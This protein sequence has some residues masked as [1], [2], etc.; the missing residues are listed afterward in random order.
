MNASVQIYQIA[1]K[2]S[3]LQQV[4]LLH[5]AVFLQ[6]R[7]TLP[8]QLADNSLAEAF[9]WFTQLPVDGFEAPRR[10]GFPEER[11]PL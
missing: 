8:A 5:F 4:E 1:Q 2:L 11:E 9:Y 10:D 3:P 7:L 6:Q